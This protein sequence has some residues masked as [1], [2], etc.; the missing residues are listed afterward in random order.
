MDVNCRI[1]VRVAFNDIEISSDT[2]TLPGDNSITL[3]PTNDQLT[4]RGFNYELINDEANILGL[5]LIDINDA[6]TY[7]GTYRI[8]F[9]DLQSKQSDIMTLNDGTE[10]EIV[11]DISVVYPKIFQSMTGKCT[12]E[13]GV[14]T[15]DEVET[16]I[17]EIEGFSF[18]KQ[19]NLVI[20]YIDNENEIPEEEVAGRIQEASN[21][22]D[23][24]ISILI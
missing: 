23:Y 8:A 5:S 17:E 24:V 9:K 13:N 2:I 20:D 12:I 6:N 7:I 16:E 18:Y 14:L 1:T 15:I 3:L 19:N 4:I 10:S 21:V 22:A 11:F